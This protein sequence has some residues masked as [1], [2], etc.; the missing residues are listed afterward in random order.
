MR[1]M[2]AI[3]AFELKTRLKLASTYVYFVLYAAIAAFWMAA[4]GGAIESA[5]VSFGSEKV[6]INGPYGL[7]QMLT[8]L[9]FM[10]VS[11]IA[12]NMGRAVQQDFEYGTFHFLFTAPIRK[13]D[14]VLGRFLGAYL[15][16][17]LIFLGIS[18]GAEIGIHWPGV[19]P[20]RV[21]P[22]TLSAYVRPYLI[23]ILPNMLW[24]GGVFFVMA[25]LTRQM[26]PVYITGVLVLL[27][28]LLSLG[29]I[30][31]MENKTRAA[32]IDP[33]GSMAMSV[34]TRYWSVAD[35]NARPVPLEGVLLWNRVIWV[36][37]GVAV[38]AIGYRMFRMDYG[39]TASGKRKAQADDLPLAPAGS[40]ATSLPIPRTSY[41]TISWL[42]ALPGLAR[43]YLSEIVRS[44]R[45][46][47]IVL[48]GVIFMIG[49]ASNMGAFY[50]TATWPVT[51]QVLEF[52]SGLFGLFILVVTAIYAG[53]LVWREREARMDEIADAT[54]HPVW[55]PFAA[56]LA[57]LF[58]VQA[59][60]LTVV[61]V[62]TIGIQ[63]RYGYTRFEI[64]HSLFELFV[65]QLPGYWMLAALAL[66]MHVLI[67]QKYVGHFLV[68]LWF[69]V[70]IKLPDFGFEDRL[71]LFGS[72]P[73]VRYSDMNGYGHFL[74]GLWS[75][76]VYWGALAALLLVVGYL[77][78]M[79]GRESGLRARMQRARERVGSPV[80]AF[81][82]AS[83]AIAGVSGAW[84]FHNTHVLNPFRSQHDAQKLQV[85]Y[86]KR[87]K[88]LAF[89]PQ[90]RIAGGEV[91]VDIYPRELRT[92]LRG[93]YDVVNRSDKPIADLYVLLPSMAEVRAI[94]SDIP[95]TLAEAEPDLSWRHYTL[96]RA[97]QPG[98]TTRFTFDIGY[99]VKGFKNAGADH[100]VLGNGTFV[101]GAFGSGVARMPSFGYDESLEIESDRDRKKFGLAPKERMH[102]LD[103]QQARQLGFADIM[104]HYV[105]TIST[106]V[107]QVAFTSGALEKEWTDGG[108]RYFRY[109][110]DDKSLAFL[111]FLSGR[112]ATRKD[113][114]TD[115][116]RTVAIEVNYHEG[117]E[118]DIDRMIA[119]V[120]DSLDYFTEHFTPYQYDLLR[121]IEF[122]RYQSFAESFSNTVPFSES[123]GFIA[124]VDDKDPKDIDYP[125]FVTAHE[126]AHQWWGHQVTPGNVQG[127]TFVAESLAEYSALLVLKHK[128][129][130]AKMHRFL[131]YELDRYLMGRGA[132]TKKEQP[133]MRADGPGYLHY[134]KGSLAL[135]ALQDMI[136]EDTLNRALS[137]FATKWNYSGP[138]F[139]TSRDLLAEI[140]KVTPADRKYLIADLFENITLFE[141]QTKSASYRELPDG[142]FE[143]TLIAQAK[144]LRADG[145]GAQT[146]IP[147][148]ELVDVGALDDDD[149]PLLLQKQLI[150]SGDN[151]LKFVVDKRPAKA[152]VDPL[153]KLINRHPEDATI[154]VGKL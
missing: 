52:T 56:K 31:D 19:D 79:R 140:D 13:R 117:H 100:T 75:F 129:G 10:G 138:P 82:V 77:F 29:L 35:R 145:L 15:T 17:L 101:N 110:M 87:Y 23:A 111:P 99:A 20:S 53:E 115:G 120:K 84:I 1:T 98:E 154:A 112:Y 16:L 103:D 24:L 81:A 136:G 86:E 102:D 57:T 59:L 47:A 105:A 48:G 141:F 58:A 43:L 60:L 119:G 69:L 70:T 37:I 28:Y 72:T 118:F 25:A 18:L 74:P 113:S 142:K 22:A 116:R 131:R 114:W 88:S 135:Y 5:S 134:Q 128:Y 26:A 12:A 41:A 121:I 151:E 143:V 39:S 127:A 54:P 50:G 124:R 97:L 71:Y 92:D 36:C 148:S 44:P 73:N 27:G 83:V 95:L 11:V 139:A 104:D 89:A 130:D 55:L 76:Q 106:D 85:E 51:Y 126:V 4:A 123:I 63:L 146:E 65:L 45:F 144:K 34:L 109:R 149:A 153:N 94:G 6:L 132:E 96:A 46:L 150:S 49:N 137:A 90:P 122:P 133:L 14:Y 30:G 9:G 93:H 42:R 8:L 61:F 66:T 38:F 125:Y 80:I 21:G 68:L 62:C 108:R 152:G 32:L 78:W 33:V 91:A 2:F 3:A 147:M 67:N 64:G 7:A 40:G 107:D